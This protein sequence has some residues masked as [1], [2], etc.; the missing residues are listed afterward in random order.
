[1]HKYEVENLLVTYFG[2]FCLTVNVLHTGWLCPVLQP[3]A[4]LAW[5]VSPCESEESRKRKL[6]VLIAQETD[7]RLEIRD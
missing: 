5:L 7:P 4:Y 1:M 2:M 3:P 6:S